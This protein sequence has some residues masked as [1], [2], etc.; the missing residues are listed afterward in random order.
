MNAS[1]AIAP[2]APA[3]ASAE[4]PGFDLPALGIVLLG[5]II[6]ALPLFIYGPHP[7]AHDVYEHLNYNHFFS[8]QFWAGEL[9]PRWLLDMN[10]GLGSPSLFVFPCLQAYVYA[11]LQPAADLL[12]LDPFVTE[13]FLLLLASGVCA[14]VWMRDQFSRN[15]AIAMALAYM[16]LPYHINLDFYQRCALGECWALAWIPLVLCFTGRV[17]DRRRGAIVGLAIAF[18]LLVSSHLIS[19]LLTCVLPP[20]L[21]LVFAKRGRRLASAGRVMVGMAFGA[22]MASFYL[23]PALRHSR[24]FL[25]KL[26]YLQITTYLIT[27]RKVLI[28][29]PD[30]PFVHPVALWSADAIA[31]CVLCGVAVLARGGKASKAQVIFWLAVSAIP[32]FL[33]CSASAPFW[34]AAHSLFMLIQYQFRLNVLLCL[35]QVMILA[36]LLSAK[37]WTS[38]FASAARVLIVLIVVVPW[39]YSYT[40]VWQL[41]LTEPNPRAE[42]ASHPLAQFDDDGWFFQFITGWD[43][44]G[45]L[46]AS[47]GP[48]ARFVSGDGAASVVSWRPRHIDIEVN[49][50]TGG[51]V[52]V[53]QFY[54]PGWRV[55]VLPS[56]EILARSFEP[57]GLLSAV[58]PA[59]HANLR[60]DMPVKKIE[61]A[62][63]AV[64]IASIALA[65]I[66][67][68]RERRGLGRAEA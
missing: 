52:M 1:R 63:F 36:A 22:A 61:T 45:M 48:R 49:T 47:Q 34:M 66:L 28:D 21:A 29:N 67:L 23:L 8:Q 7:K 55:T 14:F 20:A 53:N 50:P 18:A 17:I 39:L 32:A 41:Y 12:R 42:L 56:H 24:N 44:D 3:S 26:D 16:L 64:S 62:G 15:V 58:V 59:G 38:R 35:A 2:A 51:E 11:F 4:T 54:Y 6:L 68:W 19:V 40:Q 46:R 60:F 13:E 25:V 37:G 31:V 57:V 43:T 9:Y 27:F 10:H 30:Q 65:G 5:A 33:M